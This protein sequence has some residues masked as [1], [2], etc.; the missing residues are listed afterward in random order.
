VAAKAAWSRPDD[1]VL[2]VLEQATLLGVVSHGA[3]PGLVRLSRRQALRLV[4]PL[5]ARD[6]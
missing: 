2:A 5:V 1:R 6:R 4:P 3:V